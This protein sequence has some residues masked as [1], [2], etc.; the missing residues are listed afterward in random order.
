MLA[1][2]LAYTVVGTRDQVRLGLERIVAHTGADEL[3]IASQ[4]FDHAARLSS[5]EIAASAR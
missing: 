4:I 1:D 3:M 2:M 5:Y